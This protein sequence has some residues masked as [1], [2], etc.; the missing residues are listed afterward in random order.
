MNVLL[1]FIQVRA[2]IKKTLKYAIGVDLGGTKIEIGL[3]DSNGQILYHQRLQTMV[4]RGYQAIQQQMMETILLIQE[5]AKVQ[6]SGIGIGA[7]GQIEAGSGEV[8]FAPNLKWSN[9]PLKADLEKSLKLP[10]LIVNDVRA[11]TYGEWLYGAGKDCQNLLCI[12]IGTG[13]GGGVVSG[14]RLLEGCTNVLGEVGHVTVNFN[15][16]PCTCGKLGCMEAYAGGWGIRERT[17]EAIQ[18]HQ[19]SRGSQLLMKLVEQQIDQLNT[20]II[21]QAYREGNEIAINVINQ[22][23]RALTSGIASL[24]NAFNPC[25]LILGGGVIEGLPEWVQEIKE[26]IF[27]TSLKSATKSLDIVKANLG[28][29]V[30]I[31]GA[32]AALLNWLKNKDEK[33]K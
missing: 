13:I 22:A 8:I 14:G 32:A 20:K 9:V 4:E 27:K 5:Q 11:I 3:I 10:V 23:L 15:G 25:R 2:M 17:I 33:S 21:V 28:K 24:V 7:A 30:G 16:P 1:I 12:F 6:I 29:E 31:I 19:N 26:Y 18:F